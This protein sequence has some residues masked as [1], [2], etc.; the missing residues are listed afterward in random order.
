M[1]SFSIAVLAAFALFTGPA[2]CSISPPISPSTNPQHNV[3]LTTR[4]EEYQP[5]ITLDFPHSLGYDR[6]KAW[7][8]SR[9]HPCDDFYMHACGGFID[10][11]QKIHG[12]DVLELMQRSNSLLMESILNQTSDAL[13]KT[14]LDRQLFDKTRA[15][16]D[17]CRNV[18]AVQKRGFE[19]I[20]SYG[21]E[22]V[23]N[24]ER[25]MPLPALFGELH[26]DGVYALFKTAYT[27]V[28]N[29]DPKD[30]RLQF[31]PA[32]AYQ[33]GPDTVKKVLQ[34]FVH[35]G[36][37]RLPHDTDLEKIAVWISGL[38]AEMAK[39]IEALNNGQEAGEGL[40]PTQFLTMEELNSRTSLDWRQYVGP[41]HMSGARKVYFWGDTDI[42]IDTINALT[43]YD[44]KDLKYY[45]IWR[46]GV[47]HFNKL[48]EEYYRIWAADLKPRAVHSVYDDPNDQSD[49]FQNDCVT[50][51]GVQLSYLSGHLFVKYAFNTTQKHAATILVNELI[52]SFGGKLHTLGWMDE[53]TKKA[54][55]A[56]LDNM[57]EIVGYPEWLADP[58]IVADYYSPVHFNRD[59]YFENA[60]QAQVFA[61]FAPSIHQV[62][63]SF[64]RDTLYFGYP[65]QLNAFHLTDYVQIQINPGILQ[66]PLF[67][68]RNPRSMNYGSL[69]MI[70]GHEI[71]HGFDSTGYKLNKDGERK[72]WWT[73]H[74]MKMFEEGAKCF[75]DQYSR[76]AVKFFDGSLG[77]VNGKQ[78]ISENIADNGG[79]DV[80]LTAW[81]TAEAK[82]KKEFN[83]R[84]E[85]AGFGGLTKEQVFFLSFGQTWCTAKDD[86]M[87]R[88]LLENDVHA[89]NAVRVNGVLHNSPEFAKAFGCQV[90]SPMNP[91][92][93]EGR[94]FLY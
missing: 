40:D 91:R 22:I 90:G 50:E 64:R 3:H 19:P 9:V 70:I 31:Y 11:Y 53:D 14:P 62:G 85:E 6:I 58:Q 23:E 28:E 88:Y 71:T 63:Q 21:Y 72:P 20:K 44:P 10:R 47:S 15:Y 16:Y 33:V 35:H 67:S 84:E 5:L 43:R 8:D 86:S 73:Q 30:L 79:L 25:H 87:T 55:V 57:I 59:T 18:H 68:A 17:S 93:D 51:T 83:P 52:D 69:G 80:A 82:A 46:L 45:F 78:T 13:G 49:M 81:K 2:S 37:L 26:Q 12:A 74:S 1:V 39:F 41:L 54:A 65:W 27:K 56:K 7:M 24:C 75:V 76:Y 61:L 29:N 77:K 4:N 38:E 60:V 89:P 48:S 32:P 34:P 94:C 36:I 66:L 92:G 42:W